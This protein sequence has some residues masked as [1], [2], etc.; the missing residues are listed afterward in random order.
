MAATVSK[1]EIQA[2]LNQ[3]TGS[4]TVYRHMLGIRYTEGVKHLAERCGA[5]WLITAIGSHFATK[6]KIRIEPFLIVRLEV[7]HRG[8]RSGPMARLT[9][10][11]DWDRS[12]PRAYPSICTQRIEFTDMPLDLVELYL[13]N[14]VLMLKRER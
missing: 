14:R 6:R 4:D 13:E 7:V 1:E 2:E 9:F 8:E 11:T 5:Y 3:F 12:N 10:H